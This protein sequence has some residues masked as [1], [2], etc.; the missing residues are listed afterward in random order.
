IAVAPGDYEV[1][2][3]HGTTVSRCELTTPSTLDLAR[4][5]SEPIQATTT[6]GGG[7]EYPTRIELGI[8]AGPERKDDYTANLDSFGYNE[9]GFL[10]TTTTG[11]L[12]A[13]RQ[14]H[15]WFWGGGVIK[16]SKPQRWGQPIAPTD[17]PGA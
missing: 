14:V 12:L 5:T 6:K 17:G 13:V 4:C 8:S 15:S 9:S 7:F 10:P 1:I 16:E 2:V 3:R 11:S